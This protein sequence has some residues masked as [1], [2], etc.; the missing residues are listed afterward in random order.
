MFPV[1][2]SWG[3]FTLYTFGIFLVVAFLGTGYVF[4]RKGKEE[5]YAEDELF[6]AFLLT[7]FW[8]LLWGRIGF[9]LLHLNHF[10]LHVLQWVNFFA[11]PGIEP[12]FAFV[13]GALFL[14]RYAK[15]QKWNAFEVLDYW[16]L[17]L[18]LGSG[19]LWIGSFFAGSGFGNTT[20]LPWGMYFP[21]VFDKRH[22]TQI[23]AALVFFLLFWFLSWAEYHYRTFEWYRD[24]KHSA[25]TGFLFCVFCIAYGILG[26]GLHFLMQA[27][28]VIGGF[29]LDL[30]LSI[31]VF[32]TGL[33]LLYQRSGRSFF[34]F[35]KGLGPSQ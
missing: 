2:F 28:I 34:S 14:Y 5:H 19:I 23:Y 16:S 30:P 9:V 26:I 33:I 29:S 22:P 7:L 8:A 25:Q 32:L 21:G 35:R 4:W 6:D 1:L 12:V 27:D 10:G 15:N 17:A 20:D 18:A 24:K 11:V 31:A 3:S 13:A